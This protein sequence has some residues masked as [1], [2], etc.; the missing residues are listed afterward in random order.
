MT[1]PMMTSTMTHRCTPSRVG[2]ISPKPKALIQ[3]LYYKKYEPEGYKFSTGPIF[4]LY[5]FQK[6]NSYFSGIIL[7]FPGAFSG[8]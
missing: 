4:P 8:Y 5:F 6:L 7:F 3:A 2:M 1:Y